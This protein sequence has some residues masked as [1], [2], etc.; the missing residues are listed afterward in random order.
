MAQTGDPTGTG[1]GGSDKPDLPAEFSTSR[2]CAARSAWRARPIRTAPTASSS[3]ILPRPASERPVHRLRPV[4][5]GM[6][7]VDLIGEGRA[8]GQSGQDRR[9]AGRIGRRGLASARASGPARL[10]GR[11]GT[12][13]PPVTQI[14]WSGG[15][16]LAMSPVRRGALGG[17]KVQRDLGLRDRLGERA[18]RRIVADQIVELGERA[19][20]LVARLIELAVVDQEDAAARPLEHRPLDPG[21]AGMDLGRAVRGQAACADHRL[22]GAEAAQER[23]GLRVRRC[24]PRP[25]RSRPGRPPPG[26]PD[27]RPACSRCR[28]CWSPR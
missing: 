12:S 1:R 26:S 5:E 4:V 11:R 27:W 7:Y 21:G 3:S 6:E 13:H 25:R 28:G 8:A 24:R 17:G 22:V 15:E 16:I 10:S 9:D 19:D 18:R 23:Q 2:S 14:C 20:D